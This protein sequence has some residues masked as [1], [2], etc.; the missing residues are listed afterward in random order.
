[1]R[2]LMAVAKRA[3]DASRNQ[4]VSRSV[5]PGGLRAAARLAS[6]RYRY[7]KVQT[8]DATIGIPSN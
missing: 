6:Q 1:M 4:K 2:I 5:D 3:F 8:A 7:R